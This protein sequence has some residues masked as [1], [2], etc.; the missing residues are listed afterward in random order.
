LGKGTSNSGV[1]GPAHRE[2]KKGGRSSALGGGNVYDGGC[3]EREK[4]AQNMAPFMRGRK[5]WWEKEV[6]NEWVE[7]G[8]FGLPNN[9]MP[10][11]KKEIKRQ[12]A[13]ND[14]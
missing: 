9:C 10:V 7:K 13:S 8:S 2:E 5:G 11:K 4:N 6:Y 14:F 1:Y 12:L 3:G